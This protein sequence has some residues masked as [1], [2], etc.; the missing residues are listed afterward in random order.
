MKQSVLWIRDILV[1]IRILGSVPLY[2]GSGCGSG[3]PK[4][5]R[6]LRIRIHN[7][8]NSILLVRHIHGRVNWLPARLI[9]F[10]NF[11][12]WYGYYNPAF[13]LAKSANVLLFL[14]AFDWLLIT[15]PRLWLAG[16]RA[17]RPTLSA[18]EWRISPRRTFS[19]WV[20]LQASTC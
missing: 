3:R 11:L 4:N 8:G 13:W 5:V 15:H 9:L 7:T 6:I 14:P 19:S 20:A 2:N 17:K 1:R 18:N 12:A 16:K 10:H